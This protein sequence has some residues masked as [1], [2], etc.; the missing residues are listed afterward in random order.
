MGSNVITATHQLTLTI[1]ARTLP[2]T[3]TWEATGI[4]SRVGVMH[5]ANTPRVRRA[6][7]GIRGTTGTA[8]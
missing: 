2:A 4:D 5:T 1:D 3:L 7:I 6:R 8:R